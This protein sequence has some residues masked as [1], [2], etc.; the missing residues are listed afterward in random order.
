MNTPMSSVTDLRAYQLAILACF[1]SWRKNSRT[2]RYDFC[3]NIGQLR[4]HALQKAV[5]ENFTFHQ[6]HSGMMF[7][8]SFDDQILSG[9]V[10]ATPNGAGSRTS[11][12]S[13]R[14]SLVD[15]GNAGF[16]WE[17][18]GSRWISSI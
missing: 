8:F 9:G 16:N 4:T 3:N 15:Y 18:E 12:P 14:R 17:N 11:R 1:V 13:C 6:Y 7:R 2:K 5:A 10:L